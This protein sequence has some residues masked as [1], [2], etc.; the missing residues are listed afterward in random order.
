MPPTILR[1]V[2]ILRMFDLDRTLDFYR[3]FLGFGLDW[4]HRFEPGMPAFVQ[5]SLGECLLHLSQHH[6]DATP[7]SA[8]TIEVAGL[9][10]YHAEVTSKGYAFMRPGIETEEWGMR[11]M[12]VYDPASNKIHF[13]ERIRPDPVDVPGGVAPSA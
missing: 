10:A 12:T 1:T 13:S 9:D 11:T 7:G 4:E 6:G 8:L 3:G 5:V 2:P